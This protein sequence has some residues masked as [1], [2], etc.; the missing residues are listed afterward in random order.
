[1]SKKQSRKGAKKATKSIVVSLVVVVFAVM[2]FFGY[3]RYEL[4][5]VEEFLMSKVGGLSLVYAEKVT[6]ESNINKYPTTASV[7][8][9]APGE[10]ILIEAMLVNHDTYVIEVKIDYDENACQQE[11]SICGDYIKMD[12]RFFPDFPVIKQMEVGDI[13]PVNMRL[14]VPADVEEGTY[15]T[16]LRMSNLTGVNTIEVEENYSLDVVIATDQLLIVD[17]QEE[18]HDYEYSRVYSPPSEL[19]DA[20]VEIYGRRTLG[21][22][23]FAF[24]MFF[25]YKAYKK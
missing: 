23:L 7:Y 10:E 21:F 15:T 22:L 24:A 16:R 5:Q 8:S 6:D 14:Q 19:R 13:E 17:V 9:A 4:G 11:G 20:L 18:P 2:A 3:Y 12:E 1:M 25:L